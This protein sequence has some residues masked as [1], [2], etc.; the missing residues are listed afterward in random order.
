[1]IVIAHRLSTI[2]DADHI[3]VVNHGRIEAQGRQEE[4]LRKCPLYANM[5]KAHLGTQD[6]A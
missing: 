2:A 4:L 6:A 5:W 3:V 1:M